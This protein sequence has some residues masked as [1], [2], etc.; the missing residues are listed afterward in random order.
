MS[1]TLFRP[2]TV[3]VSD[4]PKPRASVS[5]YGRRAIMAIGTLGFV[6]M[7]VQLSF[8]AAFLGR[9]LPGVSVASVPIGGLTRPEAQKLLQSRIQGYQLHFSV[10]T[11]SYNL[12]PAQVGVSYDVG[13]TL[14]QAYLVG[15]SGQFTTPLAIL[16]SE[17][18][19]HLAYSYSVNTVTEQAFIQKI[20]AASGQ[21]PVDAAIV[22]TNGQP[23]VQPDKKGLALSPDS[24][25]Q[26]LD[27]L[28]ATVNTQSLHL[29]P[30]VQT[31]RIT[32]ADTTPAIAETK[33][34]LATPITITYQ[35][36]SF[37]PTAAQMGAWIIY[38]KSPPSAAPGLTLAVDP[39]A[40]KAYLATIAKQINVSAVTQKVNVQ[41]GA[42]SVYQQGQNGLALNTDSLAASI[43]AAVSAKQ[44]L[45]IEAPTDP[46]AFQTQYN[47]ST[48]LAFDQYIEVNLSQQHLWVYQNHQ[49][50]FDS[51][52]TSGATGAG[53]PTATGQFAIYAKETNR[54]LVGTQYGPRYNYGVFVQYWMPF[55]QGFGLHDASWR[56]SFGGQ[57]YYYGGSHGCINLPLATAAWLFNW[58]SVGTPV[59]VHL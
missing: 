41:N 51:P 57:D 15:R 43:L 40:I 10:G 2:T 47:N 59:W 52:V 45:T 58:S 37:V 23:T 18:S 44:A 1:G 25:Q 38:N 24:V 21:A 3:E 9:F 11:T 29:N 14:D 7:A 34:L 31:A 26:V 13:T 33:Q 5:R 48:A 8:N 28:T 12:P 53:F 27:T 32:A 50:I 35:G 56:S 42:S 39:N 55:Y 17:R 4:A 46:V 22:V 20:V 6:L 16:T 54:H 30:T 36:K 19:G 49:V